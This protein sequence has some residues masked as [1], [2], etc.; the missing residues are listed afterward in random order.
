MLQQHYRK[1]NIVQ[2]YDDAD[3][4]EKKGRGYKEDVSNSSGAV[5]SD[6]INVSFWGERLT[7]YSF[8]YL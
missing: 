6:E 2:T 5:F 3:E 7:L 4:W 1:A 8:K